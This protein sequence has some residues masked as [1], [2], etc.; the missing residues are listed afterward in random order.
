[1][2]WWCS[3]DGTNWTWAWRPYA[4]AW[5]LVALAVAWIWR[6]GGWRSEVPRR[7]RIA[8]GIGLG[9]LLLGTDW[10]LSKLG[11]GYLVSA[12]MMRQVL[13][14]MIAC[15]LLLFGSPEALGRWLDA[16]PARRRFVR[17]VTH[18]FVALVGSVVIL[19]AVSTPVVVDP[20]ITSQWGSFVLDAAWMT[21]GFM[22]WLPVQP[23]RPLAPRMSGP[24]AVVYLIG[25]SIA[26]LPVAF[27]MTWS[28]TP[29]YSAYELAPRVFPRFDA[30]SD[31]ELAAAIFQVVGG[32]VIWAQIA[33]R[34][35]GMYGGAKAEKGFRGVLVPTPSKPAD[36]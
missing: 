13:I 34:F 5:L 25:V 9:I 24:A 17:I 7:R 28:D 10:P 33:A 30:Q 8:L 6:V 29:I 35:V 2:R 21:A 3:N 16:T 26:P 27:F 1:M 19:V 32:L 31:Q 20:L 15:P 11:A 4:G 12:Q 18:P 23:P 14:V 36:T 22:M